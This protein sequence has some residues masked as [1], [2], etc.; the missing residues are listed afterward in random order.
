M[1]P[2]IKLSGI[3]RLEDARYAAAMGV[4][5]LGF[6][7]DPASPRYVP[8]EKVREVMGWVMGPEPVG[9]F[10]DQ[11]PEEVNRA[12]EAA[13]F[14]LAQLDGHERPEDCAAV[15]VPVIKTFRVQHDASAEQLRALIGVYRD[16]A[17]F[18][19]LDTTGTSL[20]GGPGETDRFPKE[21]LSWRTVRALAADFDLF[22]AG[23]LTGDNVAEAVAQMRPYALDLGPSLEAAPGAMDF[24]RLGAFFDAF[25][26][27]T[28]A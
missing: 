21:S 27:A 16:A 3:T 15:E 6:D 2:E 14:A 23:A 8:P 5:Y 4:A 22:L 11:P 28:A 20:W 10:T 24:D 9:V 17:A 7:Q 18:V 19:R 26:A 1:P 12:C 25:R 13:G